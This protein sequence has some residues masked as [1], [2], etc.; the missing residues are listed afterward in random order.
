M[1]NTVS[2][3]QFLQLWN[4]DNGQGIR[5][6]FKSI[7]INSL[8]PALQDA[9][10]DDIPDGI[11][12]L[13]LLKFRPYYLFSTNKGN[14]EHYLP[15]YYNDYLRRCGLINRMDSGDVEFAVHGAFAGD[16]GQI[17]SVNCAPDGRCPTDLTTFHDRSNYRLQ[18]DPSFYQGFDD[19]RDLASHWNDIVSIGNVGLYGHVV[20]DQNGNYKIEY[21]QFYAYNYADQVSFYDHECDLECV[22]LLVN[23]ASLICVSTTHY[24]HGTP[25]HFEMLNFKF[26]PLK[27]HWTNNIAEYRG[28]NYGATG[29]DIFNSS[30]AAQ[31]NVVRFYAEI[32]PDGSVGEPLHPLVYI[33]YGTHASW[34]S[35]N[36]S[37]FGA[38]DHSGDSHQFLT[39]MPPN[40]GEVQNPMSEEARVILQFCGYWGSYAGPGLPGHPND[41]SPGA[42]LH[43]SWTWPPVDILGNINKNT[44]RLSIPNSAFE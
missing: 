40:L 21:W 35:E 27:P 9:D 1:I 14:D 26:E 29:I 32:L 24:V 13:L 2:L 44:L 18:V 39:T 38:P 16:P 43:Q 3:R 15:T 11:E 6:L 22:H 37:Y 33:E 12:A 4:A 23:M 17:L 7:S 10:Y 20:P 28:E 31:N 34:P 41:N 19:G 42:S 8:R 30:D 25:I 5:D 36:W